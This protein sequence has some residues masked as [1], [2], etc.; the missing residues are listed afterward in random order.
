MKKKVWWRLI[1]FVLV[2]VVL[3]AG[4]NVYSMFSFFHTVNAN[5]PFSNGTQPLNTAKWEGKGVVNILFMGVDRRDK[6][7]IPRS[8][9]MLLA[10]I[11]PDTKQVSV[12]SLMRDTYVDIPGYRKSKLNAAFADGGPELLIDTVQN[13]LKIPI[14]YYVA[15]DFEGFAKIIDAIGGIDVNVP[16]DFVHP[17]DGLYDIHLKKGQQHLNGQQA[18]QYVRFRGTPRADFDRTERQREVL[19]LVAEKMKSPSMIL[20]A[21]QI[22]KTIEP[23]T[24]SNLGDNLLALTTL[25]LTLD[26]GNMRTEQIPPVEDLQETYVGDEAVLI[27]DVEKVRQFVQGI[28]NDPHAG[29][30]SKTDAQA[31]TSPNGNQ[32]TPAGGGTGSATTGGNHSAAGSSSKSSANYGETG[33]VLGEFVNLRAKPGT[34]YAVIGQVYAGEVL[35]IEEVVNDWYYV[36]TSTGMY[37]YVKASL[38]ELQ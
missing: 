9:T 20:K 27:P 30:P 34:E 17:D 36:Q 22:L 19:K 13:Y 10:S 32:T 21:P 26:A 24:Q 2:I 12:F 14:H 37:G 1:S 28:I 5:K 33:K 35:S 15:T 18:L 6:S 8:D 4:Y 3:F 25:A 23:Y 11:N 7:D 38:V 31:N 29:T 16:E